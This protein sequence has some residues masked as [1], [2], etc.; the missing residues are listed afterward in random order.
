MCTFSRPTNVHILYRPKQQMV[1]FRA[2]LYHTVL[3]T[4]HSTITWAIKCMLPSFH[5][6]QPT[7]SNITKG[8]TFVANFTTQQ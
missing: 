8:K 4:V 5:N 7:K 6:G 2:G 3:G 1:Q